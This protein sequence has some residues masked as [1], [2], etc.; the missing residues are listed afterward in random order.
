MNAT[1]ALL[2]QDGAAVTTSA[3]PSRIGAVDL[4]VVLRPFTSLV[5]A[6]LVGTALGFLFWVVAARGV[7][8]ATVG[9]VSAGVAAQALLGKVAVLGV[10]THLIAELPP[11]GAAGR[12]SLL[13]A[14]TTVV[15]VAGLL[16]GALFVGAVELVP[17][18]DGATVHQLF[19]GPVA[20]A[21]FVAG[22]AATAVGLLLDQ[23]VLGAQRSSLQVLRNLVA[24]GLRFPLGVA[25]LAVGLTGSGALL[26]C[27]AL[28]LA[29]SSVLVWR[30]LFPRGSVDGRGSEP[31]VLAHSAR[32]AGGALRQHA[33]DLSLSA[34]PLLMPVVAA[35]VLAPEANARFAIAWLVATFVF[36]PPYM[37]ATA[38]FAASVHEPLDDFCRRARRTLPGGLAI[39]AVL[40]A[41]AALAAPYVLGVFGPGYA[42]ESSRLLALL[43]PAGLWMVLKDH[44]VALWRVQGRVTSAAGLAG[45][46]VLLEVSGAAAGA[47]VAGA[48]GLCVGWLL[49][50]GVQAYGAAPVV[51]GILRAPLG[52]PTPTAPTAPTAAAPGR[53]LTEEAR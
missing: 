12:R 49:A 46:G 34:G 21:V 11:L 24:S 28:P 19:G 41:A 9:L 33:L 43:V 39:S 30:R 47:A 42:E 23:A 26:L 3:R 51:H 48:P 10:G 1:R 17:A 52:P 15:T 14:G 13:R 2:R 40:G 53:P 38:L 6:Q 37:L 22:T 31:G 5:A 4:G 18:L 8:A 35:A 16:A 25:L 32:H 20:V 45:G 7:P 36:V 27:W 29:L 44:V 50:L